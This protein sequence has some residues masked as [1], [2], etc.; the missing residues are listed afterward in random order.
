MPL[1]RYVFVYQLCMPP[2]WSERLI[3]I[4]PGESFL[5]SRN[6]FLCHFTDNR[7]YSLRLMSTQTGARFGFLLLLD[8]CL[9]KIQFIQTDMPFGLF[10][11][12]KITEKSLQSF[13]NI[14]IIESTLLWYDKKKHIFKLAYW[15]SVLQN[16]QINLFINAL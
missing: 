3:S 10:F 13:F 14:Q 9:N 7:V 11:Y 6:D 5:I 2:A 15:Y 12:R 1:R 4:R 16:V 8:Y